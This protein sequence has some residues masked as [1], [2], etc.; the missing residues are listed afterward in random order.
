MW[1]PPLMVT[2][3]ENCVILVLHFPVD[4]KVLYELGKRYPWPKPAKCPWCGSVR[5][6]GHGYRERYFEGFVEW[7]WVKRFR[8]PDCKA[9]HTC[10]PCGFLKG[11]RYCAEVVCSCLLRKITEGRWVKGI[12]RQNQ[13]YWYRCLRLWSSRLCNVLRPPVDAIASFFSGKIFS[14]TEQCAPLRL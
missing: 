7:L 9:V 4:V 11:L 5:L 13:Q 3:S 12:A 1:Q 10:R 2:L 14:V 6:C 8:C